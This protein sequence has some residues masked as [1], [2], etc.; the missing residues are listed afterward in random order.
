MPMRLRKY[1]QTVVSVAFVLIAAATARGQIQT[2]AI[3]GEPF[4]VARV[5]LRLAG[6]QG[7]WLPEITGAQVLYP[8]FTNG[9]VRRLLGAERAP[10]NLEV[11]FLFQGSDPIQCTIYTPQAQTFTIA[12]RRGNGR[13]HERLLMQ[14]WRQYHGAA[15]DQQSAGDYP[16]LVQHYLTTMLARRLRLQTPLLQGEIQQ[17]AG[18]EFQKTLELI[19]DL[20]RLHDATLRE[21]S[22]GRGVLRSQP[23]RPLPTEP[24]WIP[25]EVPQAPDDVEIESIALH[26]PEECFYVRFGNYGNYLWLDRL[27]NEFGGD[28]GRMI[29]YRGYSPDP[30]L[31]MQNQLCLESTVIGDLLGG[32]VIADVALIGHDTFM[33]DG[34]AVGMLFEAKNGFLGRDLANQQKKAL[35]REKDNGATLETVKIA[36]REVA[37]LS[38][39]DNRLRSFYAVD[40]KFHLVTNS[41]HLVKRFFAAGAGERSLGQLAEFRHAR[42]VMPV[43]REDTMFAYFSTALFRNLLSPHYQI[44]LRRRLRAVTDIELIQLAQHAARMEGQRADSIDDLVRADVLPRGFGTRE[45]GS[46][47][48]ITG[49]GVVDSSRGARGTFVPIPDMSIELVTADEEAAYQ[50]QAAHFQQDWRQIVPLMV[51]MRRF[52]LPND[53]QTE[54]I[55][56]DAH[57]TPFDESNFEWLV[58][59][60]GPPTTR[61]VQMP[62]TSVIAAQAAIRGGLV[63]PDVPQHSLFVGV[64]DMVPQGDLR[65]GGLLRTL[66]LLQTTPGYLGAWPK[67]G[68]IDM[69]PLG[70]GGRPDA[71]GFTGYPLGLWRRQGNGFSVLSFNPQILSEITP[72][73]GV[74]EDDQA[75]HVRINVADLSQTK[76]RSWLN[77]LYYERAR[78][79]SV[80]NARLM[81][82]LIQQLKIP[83]GDALEEA[84]A[85][86]DAQFLCTLGGKYQLFE[87]EVGPPQ[88]QS[89]AWPTAANAVAPEDYVAPAMVWFRGGE[90]QATKFAD[91]L[92]LHAEVTMKRSGQGKLPLLNLFGKQ[93]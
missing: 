89:T 57:V 66:R 24:G 65:S 17:T 74:V 68:F 32:Q 75:A 31:R 39:A 36:D 38:T 7:S 88:W 18:G 59:L 82:T 14:W 4:G 28:V 25:L 3:V 11:Y 84:E 91:R 50:R 93:D 42:T 56:V 85:L 22:S 5:N 43:E 67:P 40:G 46:G 90:V 41:R 44:E 52:A 58:S 6:N 48:I 27:M 83:R 19:L 77:G 87:N 55:I 20:E 8:A 23:D 81:H 64:Q 72:Q 62:E 12:P 69:L 61:R 53:P 30:S 86:L 34:S 26:V 13:A 51:A 78:Q 60:L 76:L 92:V 47:P 80:G 35:A 45:N 71:N 33:E 29:A 54:R 9:P 70:L 1:A 10:R 2:E 79:T 73:L 63:F 21:T 16:P 15:H 49:Q 37:Y